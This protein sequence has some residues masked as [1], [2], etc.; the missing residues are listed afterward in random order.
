M[1]L[2]LDPTAPPYLLITTEGGQRYLL[3]SSTEDE[4]LAVFDLLRA[5]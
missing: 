2:C 1:T 5:Q 4:T 3:G